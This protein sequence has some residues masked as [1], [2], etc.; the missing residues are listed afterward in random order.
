MLLCLNEDNLVRL[1]L[2]QKSQRIAARIKKLHPSG[3]RRWFSL[4]QQFPDIIS[5]S[6]GEPDFTPPFHILEAATKAM[7]TGKTHYTPTM[8]IPAL[9]EALAVKAKNDYGLHYNPETEILVTVGAT[10]AVALALLALIET[11]DEVLI[12][13]P[14]F[15]CYE[16]AVKMAGG[17]P[18]SVPLYED[19]GFDLLIE[20]VMSQITSKSRVIIV[21]S[22]HNPTGTVLP[23]DTLRE[24]CKIAVERDLIVISDE[25][26]EKIVYD[27]NKFYCLATY[28][29]MRDRT[30]VVNSFSKTYAMTG[31][32]VGYVMGCEELI[33]AV[34]LAHQF[35]VACVDGPAQYAALA[36]LEGPQDF[37]KSMVK[38]F[39]KR[40]RLI[41]KRLNEI[42]GFK[43]SLPKGAF[44]V[45]P[46]IKRFGLSSSEFAEFLIKEAKVATVPGV[47]FGKN[48]EGYM[49]FSYAASYED[50]E[51]A[52]NRI[53]R[54]VKKLK[55]S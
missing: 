15:V 1:L 27:E 8:G 50:I 34:T 38:E 24:L 10:E 22:P 36:A 51:E 2:L 41:H 23:H 25:V 3:I 46:N 6:L 13:D 20:N 42:E 48:G 53:E 43:C 40:R 21:N 37:V 9:R 7:T 30:L 31:F 16:P 45:F 4:A 12:P 33:G 26:Y 14:G 28:P 49:R 47:S 35:I 5:L 52:L 32:R 44:Y 11:G 55:V 17:T 29:E 18:V 39:D 54:A 19:D